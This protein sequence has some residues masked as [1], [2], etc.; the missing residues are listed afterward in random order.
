MGKHLTRRVPSTSRSLRL[1]KIEVRVT[2]GADK[3]R[4]VMLGEGALRIGTA[5]HCGLVLKDETVSAEHCELRRLGE[6]LVIR[7]LGS[8][9]GVKLDGVWILEAFAQPGS[10]VQLGDHELVL[11][12]LGSEEVPLS[13]EHRFG[14][15]LGGSGAMRALFVQ[16]K[17]V[18]GQSA[19]LLIEGETGT[20]KERAAQAVHAASPRKDGPFVVFDCGATAA[21]LIEAELFGHEKGAFT[22]A[23]A[24]RPGL[25]EA[26]DGGTLV[27]DE[28]GELPLELQPKLLRLIESSELRPVG[29]NEP[30]KLDLRIIACTHRSLRDEAKSG[31]FRED[32]YYRLSALKVRLPALRERPDDIPVLVDQFLQHLRSKRGFGDLPASDQELLQSHAWPGNVRELRNVVERL[33]AFPDSPAHGLVEAVVNPAPIDGGMSP[34]SEARQNALSDF[35]QRYLKALLVQAKGSISEAARIAGVSRQFMQQALRRHSLR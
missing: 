28:I 13:N 18:A 5:S 17:A 7:D 27:L 24:S 22:G 12:A 6:Q 2:H 19:P 1:Q 14:E 30:R 29:A 11:K 20:G 10:R 4:S 3:G 16:L 35:E 25:A 9:N 23:A 26:A 31:R 8:T 21:S 34:W 33:V 15:L 32:L